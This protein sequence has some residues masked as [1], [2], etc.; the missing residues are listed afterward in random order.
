M[1]FVYRVSKL[2]EQMTLKNQKRQV[3]DGVSVFDLIMNWKTEINDEDNYDEL[4]KKK[5]F[6]KVIKCQSKKDQFV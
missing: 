3:S 1:D 2:E 6:S 5:G 4:F